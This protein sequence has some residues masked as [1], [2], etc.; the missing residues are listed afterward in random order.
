MENLQK[1]FEVLVADEN[2]VTRERTIDLVQKHPSLRLRAV[3]ASPCELQSS[4]TE[5]TQPE[6]AFVSVKFGS[7]AVFPL[8][9]S[10]PNRPPIVL[11]SQDSDFAPEAFEIR[12]LDYLLTPFGPKR[13]ARTVD[14]A[15]Q[16]ASRRR[17][18]ASQNQEYGLLLYR[19]GEFDL[20]PFQ[21]IMYLQSRDKGTLVETGGAQ[22]Q[23]K[24][25]LAELGRGLPAQMFR[26]IHKQ[27]IVN[28]SQITKLRSVASGRYA[29]NLRN[30]PATTLPV[31]ARYAQDLLRFLKI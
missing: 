27:Y 19:S 22:Y 13:F 31:G 24:R 16:R 5:L 3:A 23:S 7:Q 25:Y 6:I 4:L 29:L 26:R 17:E 20:I 8:L 11:T 21:D 30:D 9:K 10:I 12:A 2:V 15:L 14:R 18:R 1:P 28:I